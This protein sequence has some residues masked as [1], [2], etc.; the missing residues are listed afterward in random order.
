MTEAGPCPFH[1]SYLIFL[2]VKERKVDL[3]AI[4]LNVRRGFLPLFR[5]DFI[6]GKNL[7]LGQNY[8][9]LPKNMY[10]TD[11]MTL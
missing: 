10:K 7:Y 11:S 4:I 8:H 9:I 3:A 6:P 1:C 2:Y 5:T